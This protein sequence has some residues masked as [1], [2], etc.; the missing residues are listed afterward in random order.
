M[1]VCNRITNTN[2]YGYY[3]FSTTG[4][5]LITED[6]PLSNSE[7]A[8]GNDSILCFRGGKLVNNTNPKETITLK[9]DNIT[10]EAGP[11]QIFEGPFDF[12]A[13]DGV[14]QHYWNMEC[15]YPQWFGAKSCADKITS[16]LINEAQDSAEAAPQ[17]DSHQQ[18]VVNGEWLDG[19][20]IEWTSFND[21]TLIQY[22]YFN[23]LWYGK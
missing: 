10:I 1:Y 21:G 4:Y 22:Y 20:V 5:Y 11:I 9:G 6:V 8:I 16:L 19:D 15:A 7:V 3:R 18:P 13:S 2:F 14:N 12:K 17:F 23:G